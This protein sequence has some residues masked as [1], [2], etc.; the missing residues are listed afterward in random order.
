MHGF[1]KLNQYKHVFCKYQH[2]L[3]PKWLV[4]FWKECA[5]SELSDKLIW[6]SDTSTVKTIS[7]EQ[8]NLIKPKEYTH[9]KRF[10]S[11]CA[12]VYTGQAFKTMHNKLYAKIGYYYRS[13]RKP[14]VM[15][16]QEVTV[17]Q[18]CWLNL[19][20]DYVLLNLW[21]SFFLSNCGER[22]DTPFEMVS[23][24]YTHI[25]IIA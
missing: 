4:N 23:K 1:C 19:I 20:P 17:M 8:S 9:K 16:S 22:F 7:N 11:V 2:I 12:T 15:M 14:A 10:V 24:I 25:K 3:H 6:S 5:K 18:V 13:Y 21:G